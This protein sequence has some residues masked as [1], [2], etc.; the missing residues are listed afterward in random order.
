MRERI[1]QSISSLKR[2]LSQ[3]R[4]RRQGTKRLPQ[5]KE[6]DA[7]SRNVHPGEVTARVERWINSQELQ[8]PE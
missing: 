7:L 5:G 2:L 3:A 1:K 8:P 4:Q 6:R